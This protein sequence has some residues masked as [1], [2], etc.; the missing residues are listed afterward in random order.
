MFKIVILRSL[1][2][3][4]HELNSLYKQKREQFESHEKIYSTFSNSI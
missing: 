3:Q 1:A 2:V 4:C